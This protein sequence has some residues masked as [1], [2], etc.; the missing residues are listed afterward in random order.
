MDSKFK[1][2]TQVIAQLAI[3]ATMLVGAIYVMRSTETQPMNFD[4][5]IGVPVVEERGT[6]ATNGRT[7]YRG[8]ASRT[9]NSPGGVV[10]GWF[11]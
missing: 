11:E 9:L 8:Q 2:V 10:E 3:V 6:P 4:V 7:V 1:V 5:Q